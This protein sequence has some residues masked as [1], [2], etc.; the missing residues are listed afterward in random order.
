[1]IYLVV[2]NPQTALEAAT[3]ILS[4]LAKDEHYKPDLWC[5]IT[6][7]KAIIVN[8]QLFNDV[9]QVA[10][11]NSRAESVLLQQMKGRADVVAIYTRQLGYPPCKY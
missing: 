7:P 9:V 5:E 6:E 10:M 1:M 11:V 8:G 3:Q 4:R 2:T